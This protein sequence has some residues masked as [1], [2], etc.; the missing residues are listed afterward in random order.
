MSFSE[1]LSLFLTFIKINLLT[2]SGPASVGLLYDEAVG[3]LLTES[4]F[5]EA[6][7]FSSVLPGSDALQLAMFVGYAAG[8]VPGAVAAL[9]GSILP[10]TVLMLGIV[11]VLNRLRGEAWVGNFVKGLAPAVA[12]LM[13]LVAWRVFRG[14]GG[15][16]MKV[17]IGIAAASLVAY[18]LNVPSP[19]VLVVAGL[20]GL[21]LLR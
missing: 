18:L 14:E 5:V 10:P 16:Q 15:G 4:E 20:S 6:V 19:V 7:G 13:V 2:T 9:F 1:L 21:V 17:S 11:S 12:V 8:G 3:T